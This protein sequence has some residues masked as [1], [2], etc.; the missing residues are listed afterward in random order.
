VAKIVFADSFNITE[1]SSEKLES[2]ADVIRCELEDRPALLAA[3]A[4]ADVVVAE[5]A[6]IDETIINA[7]KN[8][9]GIVAYGVGTNHI[10]LASAAARGIAVHNTPGANA[11]AVA[12]MIFS[13]L[14]NCMRRTH[15]ADR[16]IKSGGWARGESGELPEEF[17]GTELYGKKIGIIGFGNIGARTARIAKAFG[18]MP[19]Y[20]QPLLI[21]ENDVATRVDTIEELI[22]SV[23]VIS[24]NCPL[25]DESRGLLSRGRLAMTK[26]GVVL[27][28]TSRGNIIDE[29]ALSDFLSSGHIAAAGL[30]VFS[31]EPIPPDSPLLGAPH[32]VLTPHIGGSTREAE[33]KISEM[34]V[35]ICGG[36]LGK[37]Q[38]Q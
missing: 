34:I 20:W 12:E 23:D 25:N 11:V 32:I 26:K 19:F 5:Y 1:K 30:D 3:I 15:E 14:L 16:Y 2:M 10:D 17:H 22:S 35:S 31:S 13:L 7:A 8:L 37:F 29:T 6:R 21:A 36:L 9:R 18:M 24:V 27:V 4:D 33:G 38:V 28:A